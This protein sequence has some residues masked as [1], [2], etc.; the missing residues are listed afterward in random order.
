MLG[1]VMSVMVA[2]STRFLPLALARYNAL[3]AAR[4]S[5]DGSRMAIVSLAATPRLHMTSIVP[6]GILIGS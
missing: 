2:S 4:I 3:S 5:A 6:P 1:N